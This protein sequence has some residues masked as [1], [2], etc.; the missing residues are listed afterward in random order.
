M[1]NTHCKELEDK[2]SLVKKETITI[3]GIVSNAKSKIT[4]QNK[5]CGFV[6]IEDYEGSGEI[7]L[8]GEEWLKWQGILSPGMPIYI[9]AKLQPRR[10]N[11]EIF[12]LHISDIKLLQTVSESGLIDKFTINIESSIIEDGLV[13]DLTSIITDLPGKT[14]LFIRIVNPAENDSVLLRSKSISINV[15]ASL[16]SYIENCPGMSYSVN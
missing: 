15:K 5:P 16:L 2:A 11:P 1:C 12:D 14:K 4:K 6:T 13:N 10:Y 3:G 8:F 9:T 7:A